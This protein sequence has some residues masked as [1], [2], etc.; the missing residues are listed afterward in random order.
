MRALSRRLVLSAIVALTSGAGLTAVTSTASAAPTCDTSWAN[1]GTGGG[2]NTAGDW[3]NGVPTADKVAC[4]GTSLTPYQVVALGGAN[5]AK[6]VVIGSGANVTLEGEEEDLAVALT[7]GS[8]GI[9][10]AGTIDMTSVNSSQDTTLTV[11]TGAKLTNSGTLQADAGAGGNRFIHA[12]VVNTGYIYAN[13]NV[14]MN[15]ALTNST[16]NN[17]NNVGTIIVAANQLLYVP[18]LT[19]YTAS[20]H[21]LKGGIY[22]LS[23]TLAVPNLDVHVLNATVD[24]LTSTAEL[25]NAPHTN[26]FVHLATLSPS[27]INRMT[28]SGSLPVGPLSVGSRLQLGPGA[29]LTS[30]GAITI[31]TLGQLHMGDG[32]TV[33]SVKPLVNHGSIFGSGTITG[34]VQNVGFLEPESTQ[35]FGQLTVTG[36]F[37]QAKP[38]AIGVVW[39]GQFSTTPLHVNGTATLAGYLFLVQQSTAGNGLTLPLLSASKRSGT[40]GE[41]SFVVF[42][43]GTRP[44]PVYSAKAVSLQATSTLQQDDLRVGYQGWAGAP[45]L[46]INSYTR[47]SNTPGDAI[48]YTFTGTSVDV[49]WNAGPDRGKAQITIDG[50]S[51][52]LLDM[53]AP[54]LSGFSTKTY[55]G[56]KNVPAHRDGLCNG[57]EE[58]AFVR[59]HRFDAQFPHERDRA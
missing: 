27:V 59:Q 51:K 2:W 56:L 36:N 57:D 11:A 13:T 41:T 18:T 31:G 32:S 38:G 25:Q 42:T 24:L 14:V 39:E 3:T 43:D 46:G 55:G 35:A 9:T 1:P 47:D 37:S 53:Y 12:A 49:D 26:A 15:A 30:T 45:D 8:G 17:G 5:A 58:S 29:S 4:L 10:N 6:G 19:N 16:S 48:S 50:K 52:G 34:S 33:K 20:T 21:T 54:T 28:V 23:G 7:V 40:F 44:L 22:E